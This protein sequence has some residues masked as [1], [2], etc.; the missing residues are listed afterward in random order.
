MI[1]SV[2]GKTRRTY[3]LALAMSH[4]LAEIRG[5]AMLAKNRGEEQWPSSRKT[6]A[7]YWWLAVAGPVW[8]PR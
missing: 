1:F 4:D 7:T 3:R 8:L 6:P 5:A 2:Y